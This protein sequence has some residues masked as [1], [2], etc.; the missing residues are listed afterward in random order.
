[1]KLTVNQQEVVEAASS[2]VWRTH[3]ELGCTLKMANNMVQLG[4]LDS[5]LKNGQQV[6]RVRKG[7]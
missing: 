5:K 1:M 6:F 7:R 3:T 2:S 4:V